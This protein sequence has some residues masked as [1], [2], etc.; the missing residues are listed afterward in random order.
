MLVGAP[1]HTPGWKHTMDDKT[2]AA[3]AANGDYAHFAH[4]LIALT[5]LAETTGDHLLAAKVQAAL[6]E[7]QMVIIRG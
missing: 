2:A 5:Q 4:H 6:D 1:H 3:E 7:L